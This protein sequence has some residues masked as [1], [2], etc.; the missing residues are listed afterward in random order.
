[1]P[2]LNLRKDRLDQYLVSFLLILVFFI[3][4]NLFFVVPVILFT[5]VLVSENRLLARQSALDY[6]FFLALM[7]TFINMIHL[8]NLSSTFFM[9]FLLLFRIRDLKFSDVIIVYFLY[10]QIAVIFVQ[11]FYPEGVRALIGLISDGRILIID[12]SE[13]TWRDRR[14][15]GLFTN[16][17]Y[18]GLVLVLTYCIFVKN[19]WQKFSLFSFMIVFLAIILTGSRAALLSMVICGIQIFILDRSSRRKL[20]FLFCGASPILLIFAAKLNLRVFVLLELFN[21]YD[22]SSSSRINAIVRYFADLNDSF[23]LLFGRGYIDFYYF[24]DGDLGNIFFML[25]FVGATILLLHVIFVGAQSKY[26]HF[27]LLSL[28]PFIVGGG[29]FGNQKLLF[30]IFLLNSVSNMTCKIFNIASDHDEIR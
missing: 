1:L 2:T 28:T 30:V 23:S 19:S 22:N 11:L 13:F 25:G 6:L 8:G 3:D 5:L 10:V 7:F 15:T 26:L 20:L 9:F 4:I 21:G 12:Y 17:N 24:F 29:I 27:V 14:M 18:A 16:P